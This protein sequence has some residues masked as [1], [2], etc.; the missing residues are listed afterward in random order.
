MS[1]ENAMYFTLGALAAGLLALIVMPAI[2]RRAVRLTRK[3]IEAATPM[4]MAEFRA[5]K[6]RLRARFA[7]EV[8][9]LEQTI[10]QLRSRL[11][12]EIDDSDGRIDVVA[13]LR[14]ESG[15]QTRVIAE[16]REREAAL[17]D[18]LHA[19]EKQAADTGQRLRM[20]E[21]DLEHKDRQLARLREAVKSELPTAEGTDVP[22]TGD[23]D[24]DVEVLTADLAIARKH[25]A[26]LE[27]QA[28]ALIG[29]LAQAP[30]LPARAEAARDEM[31][32]VLARQ[33]PE[34][35]TIAED[36][37]VVAE[38]RI[39]HAERRLKLILE[40]A[41]AV[42]SRPGTPARTLAEQLS[43]EAR[44]ESVHRA[45]I[46]VEKAIERDWGTERA[47][48]DALRE[49]LG[50][51]AE[52]ATRLVGEM[53]SARDDVAESLFERVSR[54]SEP[55]PDPPKEQARAD[56]PQHGPRA[57]EHALQEGS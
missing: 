11:T 8:H 50:E 10:E 34:P 45:I 41:G 40:Q 7:L 32:R 24:R 52:G 38:A 47:D 12:S 18:Q 49:A 4:T 56:P 42:A 48:P 46:E 36:E 5:D 19:L 16:L 27:A 57:P 28:K 54:F 26:V 25:A 53:R 23:Y 2:W 15:S 29:E 17:Y 22:L 9:R 44:A 37:L 35:A 6:D 30:A 39:A 20:A 14:S 1:V 3:R 33:P 43:I 31:A 55:P 21:R 13:K 51:I